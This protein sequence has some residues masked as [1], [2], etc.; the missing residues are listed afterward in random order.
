LTAR[1]PTG[2]RRRSTAAPRVGLF[3]LLGSGNIGNDASIESM[4]G[5]LR[6]DHSDV[7]LDA[8][9]KGPDRLTERFGVA[10]IPLN[11]YQKYEKQASGV[12]AIALKALGKG[13]DVFRTASWVRRH[14]VVIVPGTGILEAV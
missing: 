4:L 13:V 1:R 2:R 3:G 6:A 10:A 11:W 8:M 9:C 12:S 14:D 7:V 5:Y